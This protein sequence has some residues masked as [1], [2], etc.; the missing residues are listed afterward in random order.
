M[1]KIYKIK[2]NYVSPLMMHS[3]RGANPLDPL[4]KESKKISSKRSKTEEDHLQ[5]MK[6][7]YQ[8]G[9]YYDEE[10][11][12]F[13]PA[14]MI[15]ACIREGAKANRNGTKAK[16]AIFVNEERIKLQHDGPD[17]LEEAYE[18]EDMK[19]VRIV[20]VNNSK[21]LRC[22]PRFNRWAIEFTL[23][24][25]DDILSEDELI[26]AIDIAGKQKGLGDYRPRYGR[27]E[28]TVE[29]IA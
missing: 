24:L 19:D 26:H 20:T 18:R 23:T 16:T 22:R 9:A 11:G 25:E 3:T 14:E 4:A 5:L 21:I 8:L 28:A 10:I 7:D 6:L 27:F 29:E 1:S 15:E 12:F 2:F 13:L 17:T